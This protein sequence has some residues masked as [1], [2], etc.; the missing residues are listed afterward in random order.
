MMTELAEIP[1]VERIL[2]H[3]ESQK[4]IS[5]YGR[6]LVLEEIRSEL[7]ELRKRISQGEPAPGIERILDKV[8]HSLFKLESS[9]LTQVINAT[10]V[11]LHTNLGRAPLSSA[12]S[13]AVTDSISG[14]SNVEI[15][16]ATGERSN[17]TNHLEKL[18]QK[19]LGIESALVVNNNA[20]AVFLTLRALANKR[21][22]VISRNQLVEIGGG[23]RIPEIMRQSGA[24]LLE[25]GTTNQIH[26]DDYRSAIDEGGSVILHVHPSNFKITGYTHEPLLSEIAQLAHEY[27]IP[28]IDDL[29]SGALMDTTR[30]GLGHEPMVQESLAAGADVIC[31]S[32][33]KLL[34]GPQAGIIAG[35]FKY[36]SVIKKHPLA[37]V[38]RADKTLIAGLEA[39]L[40]PYLKNRAEQEIP[41]WQM[42]NAAQDDLQIRVKTWLEKIGEGHFE[43]GKST[44]G[45]GSLPEEILPT[46]VFMIPIQ[47]PEFLSAILREGNP[48]VVS[49]IQDGKVCFDPRTVL[50]GEDDKL[51]VIIIKSLKHYR[52]KYEI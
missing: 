18:L 27:G 51:I 39:T 16:L 24:R 15:D 37:R 35:K 36:L 26:L 25:I 1:S 34:G 2:Q 43:Q 20:A 21:H 19:Y 4:L 22:V 12:A 13:R 45:G 31:F 7:V 38:L 40:L 3:R 49:R 47:R 42:I 52:D 44:I 23:F 48:A 30:F 17:R 46:W 9:A 5:H 33:D 11:I 10:G 6:S 14:Y 8:A 32:G 50:P 41:V 28:L 29:G